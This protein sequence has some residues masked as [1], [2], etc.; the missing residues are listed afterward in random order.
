MRVLVDTSVW[1]DFFNGHPS[2]EAE[3]LTRLIADEVEIVTCGVVIAELF[4]GFRKTRSLAALERQ[5]RDMDCLTPAEPDTYFSAA[6]LYRTLRER[7]ITVRST[8]DCLIATLAA[9]HDTFL[10][11]RDRDIGQI[12][13]SGATLARPLPFA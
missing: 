4:Q 1:A 6:T 5:F 12:L 9:E 2:P 7:G 10:L 3:T 11:A 13:A 8:I